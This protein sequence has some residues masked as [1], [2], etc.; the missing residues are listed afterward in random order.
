MKVIDL[1]KEFNVKTGILLDQVKHLGIQ[2]VT[3][4][5]HSLNEDQVGLVRSKFSQKR[6]NERIAMGINTPDHNAFSVIEVAYSGGNLKQSLAGIAKDL[7]VDVVDLLSAIKRNGYF[8]LRDEHVDD[9]KYKSNAVLE[10]DKFLRRSNIL[11]EEERIMEK[12]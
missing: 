7:K 12:K 9:I 11:K 3:H 4:H 5:M 1:A 10:F 8:Y 2:N 6:A